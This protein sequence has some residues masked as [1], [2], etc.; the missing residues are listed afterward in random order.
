MA[1]EQKYYKAVSVSPTGTFHSVQSLG[2]V[3]EYKLNKISK[4]PDF[5]GPLAVFDDANKARN[6]VEP[7][8]GHKIFCCSILQSKDS[9]LWC[10]DKY[11]ID[12]HT[13]KFSRDRRTLPTCYLP[14]GTVLA[15]EVTLLKEV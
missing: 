13:F 14:A 5:C 2:Q 7:S 6:F 1:E 10:F 11:V 12:R 8:R 4:R 15:D 9:A 3:V